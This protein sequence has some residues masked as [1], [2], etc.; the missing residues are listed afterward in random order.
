MPEE[1][2]NPFAEF[3]GEVIKKK[4]NPF[5]EFGGE[6]KKKDQPTRSG[7]SVTPLPSQDKFELGRDVADMRKSIKKDKAEGSGLAYIYNSLVGSIA[8]ISGGRAADAN[9]LGA[10]ALNITSLLATGK[11]LP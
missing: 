11:S 8:K 10:S 1:Q 7:Y 4:T 9:I 2:N 5:A 6:L 3:G